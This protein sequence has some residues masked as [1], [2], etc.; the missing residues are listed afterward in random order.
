MGGGEVRIFGSN[1]DIFQ[2]CLEVVFKLFG[3]SFWSLKA[4]LSVNF[5]VPMSIID[6][7]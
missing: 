1:F 4:H 7:E 3:H 5:Q 2:S 6:L